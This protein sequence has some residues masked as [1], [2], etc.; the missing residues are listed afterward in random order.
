MKLS[1]AQLKALRYLDI[2]TNLSGNPVIKK[3]VFNALLR[4]GLIERCDPGV[5]G[6][7]ARVTPA[8]ADALREHGFLVVYTHPAPPADAK[9]DAT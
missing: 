4:R 6:H 9:E 3:D 5:Y 8:G 2:K 7:Y 1:S